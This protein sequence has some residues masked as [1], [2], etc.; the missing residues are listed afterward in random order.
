MIRRPPRSTQSRSS[1]ASDVYKR[2]PGTLLIP[3][4]GQHANGNQCSIHIRVRVRVR[5]LC[6]S[7]SHVEGEGCIWL[8]LRLVEHIIHHLAHTGPDLSLIHIS[9]PTRPY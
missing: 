7:Q 9:E 2:Q 5:A 4:R 8:D 6:S 1:A 3:I